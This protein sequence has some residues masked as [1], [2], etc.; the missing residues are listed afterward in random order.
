MTALAIGPAVRPPPASS[1]A[2]PPSS[3]MTATAIWGLS[4]GA[5]DV[6]HACA[7]SPLP[8]SAVPVLP[9]TETPLMRAGLPEPW[10]TTP[11]IIREMM[12]AISG[13]TATDIC[14]GV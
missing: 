5:N 1:P 6:N 4:A 9:A 13:V 8:Y 10:S 11:T 3:T 7:G 14:S 12:A 2:L